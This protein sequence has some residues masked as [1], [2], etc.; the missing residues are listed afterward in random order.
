MDEALVENTKD[1]VHGD[2]RRDQEKDFVGQGRLE[3]RAGAAKVRDE[4]AGK[5]DLPL[6]RPDFPDGISQRRAWRQVKRDRRGRELTEM[7]YPQ[8]RLF[9]GDRRNGR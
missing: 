2:N 8:W 7:P 6:G 9:N 3:S 4:T 5:F 1:D